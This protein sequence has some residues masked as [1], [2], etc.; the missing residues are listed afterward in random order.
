MR[1]LG[2]MDLKGL[3]Q[4]IRVYQV[5]GEGSARTRIEA[6]SRSGLTPLV[7]RD[8]EVGLL[9]DRWEKTVEGRGQVVV[10]IGEPGIGKS[11]MALVLRERLTAGAQVVIEHRCSPYYRN[12]PLYPVMDTLPRAFGWGRE[13]NEAVKRDKLWE[14]LARFGMADPESAALLAALLSLPGDARFALPVMSPERQRQRTLETLLAWVQKMAVQQPVLYLVEDLH[15]LDPTTLELLTLLV[16]QAPA[17]RTMLLMTARPS[18]EIPWAGRSHLTLMT[19]D[20]LTRKQAEQMAVKVAGG[21][22]LPPAV[23]EHIVARTDG[24]PLFLEEL[25]KMLL[26]S[27][28]LRNASEHYELAGPLM[29]SAIPAT[30]QDSLTARLDRLGRAKEIAQLAATLG[31]SFDFEL[32]QRVA[33]ISTIELTT[34]LAELVEAEILIQ[35][36]IAP[37]A[38]YSFKHSLI[39]DAAH[40]TLLKPVRQDYH[41]RVAHVLSEQSAAGL[42]RP[43]LLA[44][45]LNEAGN[46]MAAAEQW[47]AAGERATANRAYEEARA[48]LD[49]GLRAIDAAPAGR[50]RD[51]L[52]ARL[53]MALGTV[54]FQSLFY[55]AAEVGACFERALALSRGIADIELSVLAMSGAWLFKSVGGDLDG[56]MALSEEML[57][58][59]ENV[60]M[61][62]HAHMMAGFTQFWMGNVAAARRHLETSLTLL[63]TQPPEASQYVLGHHLSVFARIWLGL[64]L[65]TLGYPDQGLEIERD[66][67]SMARSVANPYSEGCAA[68]HL[69]FLH[70]LRREHGAASA[71]A[72]SCV[73][74]ATEQGHINWVLLASIHEAHAMT[75][76]GERERSIRLQRDRLETLVATGD[77]MGVPHFQIWLA[78]HLASDGDLEEALRL[79]DDSLQRVSRSTGQWCAAE[80]LRIKGNIL[81]RMPD[82]DEQQAELLFLKALNVASEQQA[83]AFELRA[84]LSLGRL[85]QRTGR[86]SEA[87]KLLSRILDQFD[88]GLDTPDLQEAQALMRSLAHR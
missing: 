52:E 79:V 84:G 7:S 44:H 45:H 88:E 21:K 87:R 76:L 17:Q 27:G 43:E 40:Q 81:L 61:L 46:G 50:E 64:S 5:L 51:R 60:A 22:P 8:L 80:A 19:L 30:L 10:M 24:V 73:D 20:R 25:T 33:S 59:A 53:Q 9:L 63:E 26:E 13:D 83:R 31:R 65:W 3:L 62:P 16:N 77:G 58:L 68:M 29:G 57:V 47:L 74:F 56:A 39:Q 12:T 35:R 18:F 54:Y 38:S 72:K 49:A 70:N 6:A 86:A 48:H 66:A 42:A 71:V 82:P 78:E 2:T 11:R 75:L 85:W 69:A 15:W 37:R 55:T 67:V 28:Q 32:L 34:Q 41:R 36:G 4:P 14:T 1:D 23:I